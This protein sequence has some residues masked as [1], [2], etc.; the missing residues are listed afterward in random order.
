MRRIAFIILAGLVVQLTLPA[1]AQTL[2]PSTVVLTETDV[3]NGLRL[4]RDRS[5]SQTRD[6]ASGYQVTFE[7]DPAQVAP[8][9]GGIIVVTNVVG[10]PTDPVAGLDEMTRSAKQASPGSTTDLASPAVGEESR[11]FTSSGGFGPFTVAMAGTM[12]RR[13]GAVVGVTVVSAGGEPQVDQALRLA[14][15]VDARLIAAGRPSGS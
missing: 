15:V 6:G 14:Q 13:N 5:G 10:L 9:S 7:A 2:D 1:H 8:G 3:P 11:A 12:F 4:S